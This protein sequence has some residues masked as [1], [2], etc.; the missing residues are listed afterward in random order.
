MLYVMAERWPTARKYRDAFERLKQLALE[1]DSEANSDDGNGQKT[2][3]SPMIDPS[4]NAAR[5]TTGSHGVGASSAAPEAQRNVTGEGLNTM[6]NSNTM[7]PSFPHIIREIVREPASVWEEGTFDLNFDAHTATAGNDIPWQVGSGTYNVEGST[8]LD[9]S[10]SPTG[11][12]Y[13]SD[14][15]FDPVAFDAWPSE[16]DMSEYGVVLEG[17]TGNRSGTMR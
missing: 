5:A 7:L 13:P 16:V 12:Y 17:M 9:F 3:S 10:F 4:T 11:F 6:G 2:S 1:R 15:D 8:D 14:Y